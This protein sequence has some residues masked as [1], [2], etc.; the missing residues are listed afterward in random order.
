MCTCARSSGGLC[1]A[2]HG[3]RGV[4]IGIKADPRGCAYGSVCGHRAHGACGSGRAYGM[5]YGADIGCT[6][7]RQGG[8]FLDIC[9]CG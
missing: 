5:D 2:A 6:G 3:R 7:V 1:E 9:P 8:T 4:I